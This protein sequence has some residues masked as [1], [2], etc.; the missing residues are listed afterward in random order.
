MMIIGRIVRWI[1]TAART[2]F[3]CA[4]LSGGLAL[5]APAA[6][7]EIPL[8]KENWTFTSDRSGVVS[9]QGAPA[10]SLYNATSWLNDYKFEDGVIEFKVAFPKDRGFVG[11]KFRAADPDSYEHFYLRPH[12]SGMPDANQYTPVFHGNSGW[13][14]YFGPRYSTPVDYPYGEWIDVKLVVS[15]D[16]MDVY[17]NSDEPVLHVD[18]LKR[19]AA[20]GAV[21]FDAFLTQ[22]F[23]R[24]VR[25]SPLNGAA[26]K[27]EAAAPPESPASLIAEWTVSEPTAPVAGPAALERALDAASWRKLAVEDNG[28]ANLGRIGASEEGRNTILARLS[29]RADAATTKRL[30]FGY[31][32]K[33][34]A[35]VNGAPVYA[36]DNTYVTRDYRYL[37]TVG[38]FDSLLVPLKEG[39][40]EI[41]FA[42]EEAFGGWGLIAAF[43]DMNGIEIN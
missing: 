18:D 9:Y 33:V 5:T 34:V 30:D 31:S 19:D 40:N 11:I 22:A 42:V 13:Q 28:V 24:E 26:P 43:E 3:I 2:R 10:L 16:A 15:G 20:G 35:F 14:I 38:L 6:A 7:E 41:V 23:V 1:L 37:G 39:D 8:T 12:L 32:D 4:V 36:G 17:V 25:I 21:G 27:G 29:V